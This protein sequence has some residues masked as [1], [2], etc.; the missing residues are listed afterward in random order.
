MNRVAVNVWGLMSVWTC[1]A[2]LKGKYSGM[3]LLGHTINVELFKSLF[4]FERVGSYRHIS[5]AAMQRAGG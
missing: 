5:I 2:F 3:E 1:I 4:I